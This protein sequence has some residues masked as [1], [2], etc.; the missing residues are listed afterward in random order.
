[1]IKKID[2]IPSTGMTYDIQKA[3]EESEQ[4]YEEIITARMQK[5]GETREQA[6]KI[7]HDF[8]W[9]ALPIVTKRIMNSLK[10]Y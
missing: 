6:E 7:I 8:C 10:K 1:M 5:H 9:A 4:K 3:M 2:A